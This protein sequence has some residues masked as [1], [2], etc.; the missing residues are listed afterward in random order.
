MLVEEFIRGK[1]LTVAVW[2]DAREAQAFP[3]IEITTV[4]GRYDYA[5]KY[6]KGASTHI[7]PARI[8][9]DVTERVQKLAVDAFRACG[10]RGVAR[11]DMM[12][13]EDMTPYVIEINSMP[14]MTETSLVPDAGRAMGVEFPEL[15]E[16]ILEMAGYEK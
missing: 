12:L 8:P 4:S 2:G 14:G 6:T 10:C 5:S 16:K 1:E 13:G 9:L 11:A 15:C 7:I 3:V